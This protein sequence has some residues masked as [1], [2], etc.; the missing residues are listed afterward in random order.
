MKIR[1][2]LTSVEI[3]STAITIR[4]GLKSTTIAREALIGLEHNAL[5]GMIV[6]VTAKKRYK[7]VLWHGYKQIREELGI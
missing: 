1:Y 2:G 6:F 4:S 3:T 5:R 7:V